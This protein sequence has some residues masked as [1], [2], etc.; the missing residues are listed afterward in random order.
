V[1]TE[2]EQR[3]LAKFKETTKA[4]ELYIWSHASF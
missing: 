4:V 2:R 1:G 3:G